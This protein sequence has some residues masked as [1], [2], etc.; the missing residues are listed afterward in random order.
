MLETGRI[1]CHVHYLASIFGDVLL[2]RMAQQ[3]PVNKLCAARPAWRDLSIHRRLM[4][5]SD[6]AVSIIINDA[7]LLGGL[8]GLGGSINET[9]E[10]YNRSLSEDL[11]THDGHLIGAAI[12][13]PFGGAE[14][15]AQLE[16]SLA[17]P[18]M[19]A[20]GLTTSYGD[21][22]LDDPMFEPIFEVARQHN[23]PVMVHPG[24]TPEHWLKAL[25]IEQPQFLRSGIGYFLD[26]SLCVLRLILSGTLDK[27]SDVRFMFCQLGGLVSIMCGRWA[28]QSASAKELERELEIPASPIFER[29]LGEYLSRIWLDM[30]TQD[31]HAI[32]M[33]I[34]EAGDSVLVLGGDHPWTVPERGLPLQ[35]AELEALGVS[36]ETKRKVE[37]ENA[38]CLLGPNAEALLPR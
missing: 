3:G 34:A 29:S 9:C 2:E 23:V 20:V 25:R 32:A 10:A 26:D 35:M 8:R 28:N 24:S 19:G 38:L 16:R 22:C 15:V 27:Y 4:D 1:D 31:R 17:L 30:H 13:D 7:T 5:Q 14:A 18:T 11:S 21:V 12:I 6:V 36:E 37:R 33:V